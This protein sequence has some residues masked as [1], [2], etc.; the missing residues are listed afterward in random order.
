[1][2]N[3]YFNFVTF[4]S[5]YFHDS[6]ADFASGF[7][8]EPWFLATKTPDARPKLQ[9]SLLKLPSKQREGGRA[10]VQRCKPA[11]GSLMMEEKWRLARLRVWD[12]GWGQQQRFWLLLR[13][14]AQRKKESRFSLFLSSSSLAHR[15]LSCQAFDYYNID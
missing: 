7:W 10:A 8:F 13:R 2:I 14:S 9:L 11:F 4:S 6:N 5:F 15:S 12:W 1:M 3:K